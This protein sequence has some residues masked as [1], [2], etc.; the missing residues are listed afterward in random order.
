MISLLT[1]MRNGMYVLGKISLRKA[2][3]KYLHFVKVLRTVVMCMI[4]P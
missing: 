3:F 1:K 2:P 4:L